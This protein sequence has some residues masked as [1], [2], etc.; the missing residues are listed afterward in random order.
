M[1]R[2]P[3]AQDVA[4]LAGVSR[5][6]VSVVLNGR[7]D[8]NISAAKQRAV[9]EAAHQLGYRP[10]ALAL[11]LRSRRTRSLGVLTW[12][13]PLGYPEGLLDAASRAATEAGYL[14][15][16]L[17]AGRD[18]ERELLAIATLMDRQVDGFLVVAPELVEYRPSEM[19]AGS[20][21][22]LVNCADPDRRVI[23]VVP[24]E[25][26]AARQA[27]EILLE[28]GH[29]R[30][31]LVTD[32]A[33][34]LQLQHRVAG[35]RAALAAVGLSGPALLLTGRDVHS[36]AAQVRRA[37]DAAGRPTALVCT[38]ERLALGALLAAGDL[39]VRVPDE[40]SVISLED[41]ENLAAEL[42]P[43]V[44]T[45]QRPDAAMAEQALAMLLDGLTLGGPEHV[46]QLSFACPPRLRSST[47][48]APL[49]EPAGR[50]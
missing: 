38:R 23:G 3:T 32:E 20:P 5:S 49:S 9:V 31:G 6:T 13:S 16:L 36:G 2:R 21:T 44:S 35:V 26:T 37:L 42:V 17:D 40:L 1:A 27:V 24:D 12:R 34:T 25:F 14:L 48:R 11:S 10:N 4:D 19:L 43:P 18:R 28:L 46:R 45:V 15:L 50:R 30:I 41:G 7:A 39:G 8:G 33:P 47:G 29:R 22:V